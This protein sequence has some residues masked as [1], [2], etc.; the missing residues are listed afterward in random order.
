MEVSVLALRDLASGRPGR[1]GRA[2]AAQKVSGRG[3]GRAGGP[4]SP[5]RRGVPSHVTPPLPVRSITPAPAQREAPGWRP[6]LQRV[7]GAAAPQPRAC[8]EGYTIPA[9]GAWRWVGPGGQ[10]CAPRSRPSHCRWQHLGCCPLDHRTWSALPCWSV[11]QH[12]TCRHLEH[13]G[14]RCYR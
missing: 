1:R 9:R 12:L 11:Q 13:R 6:G 10:A 8:R 7:R 14:V 2:E 3:R 5:R 4:I